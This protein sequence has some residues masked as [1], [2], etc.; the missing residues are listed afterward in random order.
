M[1]RVIISLISRQW[2]MA[3]LLVVVAVGV[4]VRLGVWQLDRLEQR[5]AFNDR[6][7]AQLDQE[8][9]T[10][11]GAAL[12]SDLTAMEYRS[13]M[14]IGEYDPTQEVAIR[15]Q[16]WENQPGVHLLTPLVISGS[17]QAVLIDR[18]WIPAEDMAPE[19]WSQYVESGV[20]RIEGI[21]RASRSRPDFG[22]VPDPI[23]QPGERLQFWNNVNVPRIAEQ[24]S[25]PLLPV[26]IQQAPDPRWS[27]LPYRD[28]PDLNLTEG[29]H[30]GY[31]V[32]WF[33]FAAVL[34]I[35]Y[36]FFVRQHLRQQATTAPGKV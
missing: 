33:L 19:R 12:S 2:W 32:Q 35:G 20:V 30:L 16:V 11:S 28:Q 25:H 8:P 21:I 9:L 29:S 36:P 3:T 4:M 31:A 26:Y 10:L 34:A 6:V 18:G 27:S 5:R 22:G 24:V 15:N 23:L 7:Q 1:F 13:V 17:D 14:V